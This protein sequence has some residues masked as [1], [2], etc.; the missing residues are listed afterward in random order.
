MAGTHTS[1]THPPL[2]PTTEDD[3][4][5]RLRLLRSRRVGVATYRRLM[6]EHGD[7]AAALKA[8]PEIAMVA[9]VKGYEVCPASVVKA[10]LQAAK[11]A[12]AQL[13][14]D[15][16]A[17]YP[18]N[19]ATIDDAPPLLWALGDIALLKKPM[20]AIVG[21]RNA[22]SLGTRMAKRL[23]Q[24]LTA[25]GYVIVSGLARGIDTAAHHG[26]LDGGTIAVQAGGVDVI[27]PAE[28]AGLAKDIATK[29]LRLSEAPMGLQP[30]ARHFPSRNRIISGLARAV[31]V[32]E[33]A[34]KSGSLITARNALDQA[35]DVLAIPGHPFDARAAGCN[36]LLRDGATLVRHADDVI[37]ALDPIA[38][39]TTELPLAPPPSTS[40]KLR[41]TAALHNMILARLGPAPIAEDQ[42]LRDIEAPATS[43]TPVLVDLELDG[44]IT[45]QAGGLLARVV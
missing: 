42:L 36:L 17:D 26:A 8:L 16:S 1:S 38:T 12:G 41:D 21:A 45:R 40:T 28:N 27:Y 22:S 43:V 25:Q 31:V 23:A 6:A 44:K 15:D 3:A 30:Q 34:A 37:E 35:R 5:D 39:D 4:V 11:A 19:L 20:I 9:G 29:G 2:H 18:A 33:A 13:L 10:E 7:A 14:T 32:V 24:D